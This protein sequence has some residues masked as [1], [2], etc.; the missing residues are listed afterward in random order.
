MKIKL[1]PLYDRVLIKP[2]TEKAT[3]GI[4]VP[5]SVAKGKSSQGEVLAVGEGRIFEDTLVPLKVKVGD[6]VL[7]S[8]DDYEEVKRDGEVAHLLKEENILAIIK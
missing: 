8:K 2:K 3:G 1:L 4:Q 7:Y 5:D 6:V